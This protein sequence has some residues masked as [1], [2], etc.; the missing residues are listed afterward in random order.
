M[1][2]DKIML[3]LAEHLTQER[4]NI[5]R[6]CQTAVNKL[7]TGWSMYTNPKTKEHRHWKESDEVLEKRY[8]A[9]RCKTDEWIQLMSKTFSNGRTSRANSAFSIS[10]VTKPSNMVASKL[11]KKHK[12][13]VFIDCAMNWLLYISVWKPIQT[14]VMQWSTSLLDDNTMLNYEYV[15]YWTRQISA[16]V[17]QR[18]G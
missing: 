13:T 6:V 4:Q 2:C 5:Y 8:L 14:Y 3:S 18:E 17:T 10:C 7:H 16:F 15:N 11:K 12:K 9:Q 1:I